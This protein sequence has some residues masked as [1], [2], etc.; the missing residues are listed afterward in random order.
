MTKLV[1]LQATADVATAA[2]MAATKRLVDGRDRLLHAIDEYARAMRT[3][4]DAPDRAAAAAE[5][6][7]TK[8]ELDAARTEL[9][10]IETE[11]K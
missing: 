9:T 11:L 8:A 5:V 2:W 1:D 4:I 6:T 7:R 10:A 3:W